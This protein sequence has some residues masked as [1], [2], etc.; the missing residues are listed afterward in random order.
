MT[1]HEERPPSLT[2]GRAFACGHSAVTFGRRQV[3]SKGSRHACGAISW[4]MAFGPHEPV[5]VHLLGLAS[6]YDELTEPNGIAPPLPPR[7]AIERIGAIGAALSP[8]VME[9]FARTAPQ[10]V[11]A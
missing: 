6:L 9:A 4:W 5:L 11:A 10:F 2:G 1:T 3:R 8:L 7:S